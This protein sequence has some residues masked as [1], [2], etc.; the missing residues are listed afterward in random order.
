M[1]YVLG[2]KGSLIQ[3]TDSWDGIDFL[4]ICVVEAQEVATLSIPV[5]LLLAMALT[6]LGVLGQEVLLRAV[7]F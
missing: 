2:Q 3:T 5:S 4:C 7:D 6:D 1:I